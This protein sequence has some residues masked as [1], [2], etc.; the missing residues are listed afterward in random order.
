MDPMENVHMIKLTILCFAPIVF[1]TI[2]LVKMNWNEELYG[3]WLS[4]IL[5]GIVTILV[6]TL[7]ML[8]E[9]TIEKKFITYVIVNNHTHLPPLINP[10]PT[11]IQQN[12]LSKYSRLAVPVAHDQDGRETVYFD[13]PENFDESIIFYEELLQ[14]QLFKEI[15][16]IHQETT[17]A[18]QQSMEQGVVVTGFIRRPFEVSD[19]IK[20][21]LKKYIPMLEKNRFSK[22]SYEEFSLN[23]SFTRLPEGTKVFFERIP[24]SES[25]GVEK[26]KIILQK[27]FFFTIEI[28][29]ESFGATGGGS[30]PAGINIPSQDIENYSTYV[31]PITLKAKFEQLTA[32][33]WR[34]EEYKGWVNWIFENIEKDFKDN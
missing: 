14:Y 5:V 17:G 15:I 8:K 4:G 16:E 11:N 6:T 31:F 9:T 3:Q 10:S 26:H 25:R 23:H 27:R 24:S 34:T 19:Y 21:P 1:L 12:R 13:S 7:L 2:L 18:G 22:T 30:L 28:I 29:I 20:I 32:G 33:N